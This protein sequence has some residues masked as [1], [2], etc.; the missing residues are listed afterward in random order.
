MT[1]LPIFYI[2]YSML[3]F[4][5]KIT[6]TSEDKITDDPNFWISTALLLW[7]CFFIF[8]VIPRDLLNIEDKE[9]LILL[10]EFLYGINCI[11]YLLFFKGLIK[12]ERIA[13]T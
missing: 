1:A 11:M 5:Q 6:L 9:F 3:W 8:R 12:Y 10:R 2:L 13:K 7:S 4:L